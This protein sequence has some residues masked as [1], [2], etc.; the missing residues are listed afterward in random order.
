MRYLIIA[1][2]AYLAVAVQTTLVDAIQIGRFGPQLPAMV[3][4]AVVLLQRGNASLAIVAAIGLLEDVL[5]PG[6]LGVAMVWY[7]LLGWA[8]LDVCE[9]F[10]LRPLRRRMAVTGLFAGLLVLF[11][12]ATRSILGEPTV[13]LLQ[14]GVLA[15][16]IGFYTMAVA[17]PFWLILGWCGH[18]FHRRLMRYEV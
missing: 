18:A 9:R 16:G 17:V 13:G 1:L 2:I 7:L 10:D 6:R 14:T 3:A 15:A 11:V 8:L 12:G 4:V 5:W